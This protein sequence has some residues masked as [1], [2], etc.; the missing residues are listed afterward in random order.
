MMSSQWQA[1]G[2][3]RAVRTVLILVAGIMVFP[4]PVH[5]QSRAG[6]PLFELRVRHEAVD[7]QGFS[8]DAGATTLRARFGWR[9]HLA[10]RWTILA[11]GEY[12][13]HLL[14]ENFN[15]TTNGKTRFPVVADPDA[16]ELNQAFVGYADDVFNAKLGRQRVQFDNLRFIANVGWRQNEQTFDAFDAS[17][18]LGEHGTTLRYAYLDRVHRVLGDRNPQGEW[19]LDGHAIHIGVALPLGTVAGYAYLIDNRNVVAGSTATYG[20]RWSGTIDGPAFASKFAW[21][22]EAAQQRDYAR[23]PER[24]SVAYWR[25]EPT[26]TW[27]AISTLIGYERL[28]SNGSVGLQTPLATLHAFNGWADRFT[29]TPT[30]GLEDAWLGLEGR[31]GVWRWQAVWHNYSA[32]AGGEAYGNEID[33]MLGRD[34]GH[35]MAVMLKYAD[36]DSSGFSTDVRKAWLNFEFKY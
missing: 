9:Q 3:L 6:D 13:A 29:T 10:S 25:I 30:R 16:T 34:L 15:S 5:A 23:N 32:A 19:D 28:G 14:D 1:C 24:F 18:R 11:E 7:E 21:L 35:G 36:Y 31:H 4:M 8:R 17:W 33:L 2:L 20:L 22:V 12:I 26:L 27:G